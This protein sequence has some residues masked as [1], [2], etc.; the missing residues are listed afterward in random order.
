V[1]AFGLMWFKDNLRLGVPVF[2]SCKSRRMSSAEEENEEDTHLLLS[3]VK[4]VDEVLIV[5]G[6]E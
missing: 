4:G 5:V 6:Y 3:R 2:R 1:P